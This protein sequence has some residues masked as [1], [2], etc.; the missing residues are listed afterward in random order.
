MNKSNDYEYDDDNTLNITTV[1]IPKWP[2]PTI[3]TDTSTHLST[4]IPSGKSQFYWTMIETYLDL[5]PK[6]V[7]IECRECC[8]LL[9]GY[10]CT[11]VLIFYIHKENIFLFVFRLPSK[12]YESSKKIA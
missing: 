7:M 6:A 9:L 2:L 11:P 8:C 3:G 1:P 12:R 4:S 10:N 5:V